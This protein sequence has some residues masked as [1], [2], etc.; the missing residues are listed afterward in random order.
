MG[1]GSVGMRLDKQI[2]DGLASQLRR[3]SYWGQHDAWAK[4]EKY[5]AELHGVIFHLA[6]EIKELQKRV[7]ELESKTSHLPSHQ[8]VET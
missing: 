5:V 8:D 1:T 2:L 4:H 3:L 7:V 6:D